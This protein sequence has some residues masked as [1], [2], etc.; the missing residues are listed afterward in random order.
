M[1]VRSGDEGFVFWFLLEIDVLSD[2]K[3][4][5]RGCPLRESHGVLE[6]GSGLVGWWGGCVMCERD[7][8]YI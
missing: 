4:F 6:Y 5:L 3:I 8:R 2:G 7:T 1:I